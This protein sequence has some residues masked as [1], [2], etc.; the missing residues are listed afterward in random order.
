VILLAEYSDAAGAVSA[1]A[2]VSFTA[3]G[4]LISSDITN[5]SLFYITIKIKLHS[6]DT[7]HR[8]RRFYKSGRGKKSGFFINLEPLIGICSSGVIY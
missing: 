5:L 1:G 7:I 3:L 2:A 6:F 8:A 4:S